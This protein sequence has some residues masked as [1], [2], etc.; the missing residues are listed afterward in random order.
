MERRTFLQSVAGGLI[1]WYQQPWPTTP[2]PIITDL[3]DGDNY[4]E[5]GP[6]HCALVKCRDGSSVL[7]IDVYAAYPEHFPLPGIVEQRRMV[8]SET[9]KRKLKEVGLP[10]VDGRNQIDPTLATFLPYCPTPDQVGQK[11]QQILRGCRDSRQLHHDVPWDEV[12]EPWHSRPAANNPKSNIHDYEDGGYLVEVGCLRCCIYP[13]SKGSVLEF[14]PWVTD[15][16]GPGMIRERRMAPSSK[17]KTK[18]KEEFGCPCVFEGHPDYPSLI[19]RMTRFLT[20][21]EL[22]EKLMQLLRG[23]DSTQLYY[24]PDS[25]QARAEL[26]KLL[27]T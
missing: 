14:V 10:T 13:E 9:L 4:I 5:V 19:A 27:A 2:Q 15:Y 17:L 18:L 26:L 1:L 8:P 7:G 23:G 22:A 11:L 24:D 12:A 21:N 6:L 20:P 3:G 25:D 16:P